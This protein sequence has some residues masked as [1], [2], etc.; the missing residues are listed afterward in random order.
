M[1]R[2]MN[3][4]ARRPRISID[5]DPEFRH[6]LRLAAAKQDVTVR[7]YLLEA[8]AARLR[9]DAGDEHEGTVVMTAA[10]DPV[11]A[12]LWNNP[13]DAAYDRL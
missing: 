9:Q 2:P 4:S 7:Q 12:E 3:A 8:I 11:L 1:A 13:E 5:V 10:V 6:R